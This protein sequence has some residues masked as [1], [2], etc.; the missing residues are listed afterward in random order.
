M[1][2]SPPNECWT[3]RARCVRDRARAGNL[4]TCPSGATSGV[5]RKLPSG[6]W[7]ASYWHEGER[8]VARETF[9]TKTDALTFLSTKKTGHPAWKEPVKKQAVPTVAE[10]EALASAVPEPYPAMVLI[11]VSQSCPFPPACVAPRAQSH[12]SLLPC[13]RSQALRAHLGSR[14]RSHYCRTDAPRRPLHA[15]SRAALPTPH[16]RKRRGRCPSDGSARRAGFNSAAASVDQ[17]AQI[18]K[19]S[20]ASAIQ[21]GWRARSPPTRVAPRTLEAKPGDPAL[22]LR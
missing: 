18:E 7:Q 3:P 14:F 12:W 6:R 13:P 16:R 19:L 22:V 17:P 2:R 11:W 1:W 20:Q 9:A 10:V 5:V 15:G 4:P 21:A 8:H